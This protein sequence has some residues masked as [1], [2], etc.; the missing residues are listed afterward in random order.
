[1]NGE[2]KATKKNG[3]KKIVSR[4]YRNLEWKSIILLIMMNVLSDF[5]CTNAERWGEKT[6]AGNMPT[7]SHWSIFHCNVNA[8]LVE[9]MP[10]KV[11]E[12]DMRKEC[13][14]TIFVASVPI[15]MSIILRSS[16]MRC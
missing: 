1:M 13:Q 4:F 7:T 9:P 14:S 6:D 15:Q 16:V 11:S 10:K 2:M 12:R 3:I 5:R 8:I